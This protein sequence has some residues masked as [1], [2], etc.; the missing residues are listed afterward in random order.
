MVLYDRSEIL[1]TIRMLEI[2]NL[3]V[4]TVTLGINILDCRGKDVIDTCRNVVNKIRS[5]AQSLHDVV[6]EVSLRFGIPIVNR[7]LAIS[8]VSL[9]FGKDQA[10]GPVELALLLDQLSRE[11][12]VDFIGGFTALVQ[13]GI[14]PAA[15]HLIH[16][17]PAILT[18]TEH[19]CSSVNVASTR[20]GINVD[21]ILLLGKIIKEIAHLSQDKNGI[22]CAKLVVFANAPEDNPFMAGSFHGPGE[23]DAVINVGVSGPGVVKEM[24]RR[25]PG[26]DLGQ[27]AEI[28]KQTAFKITRVGE[29]IGREVSRKLGINFGI[30]DLS[31][32]PTSRVGDSVAEIIEAMGIDTCGGWGTTL[33][34]AILTDACK[35]GGAMA[36][37]SV[38]GLSGAFIPVS[39]DAAMTKAV[40]TGR[41]NFE[42]LEAMT[43]VCSV[44]LDM[45]A[46]PGDTP[47]EIISAIIGDEVAIGVINNK[48]VGIRIIPVVGKKPGDE[49]VW[50]GLLGETVV[51][52]VN[53]TNPKNFIGRGGRIPAPITSLR[54]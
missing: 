30:V 12:R 53:P 43:S 51:I 4:R 54:N 52:Q 48:T 34:L 36:S 24:I 31:L 5:Y 45:I 16:S 20:S 22:G 26:A 44:G 15:E 2:E 21:V 27:V 37:S 50:G 1:E 8:P 10:N 17:L 3:D 9:L 11:I 49:V 6:E 42:K 7:R 25:H 23:G 18:Q 28:I 40:K 13:K 47:E 41:L 29:L 14:T 46:I 35:K 38:G 32:A 33:A 39:E 19:I